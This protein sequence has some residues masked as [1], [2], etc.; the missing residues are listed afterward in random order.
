MSP[1]SSSNDL[2]YRAFRNTESFSKRAIP[3]SLT[4]KRP[5]FQNI[6]FGKN[7]SVRSFSEFL[8]SFFLHI[9]HVFSV[10]RREKMIRVYAW[11]IIAA[12]AYL[13]PFWNRSEVNHP[14]NTMGGMNADPRPKASIPSVAFGGNPN[15][16][17]SKRRIFWDRAVFTNLFPESSF[18]SRIQEGHRASYQVWCLEAVG[19]QRSYGFGV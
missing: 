17:R 4:R 7:C 3:Y 1:L 6:P 13:F 11:R 10:S 5:D 18:A 14:G 19:V 8:P 9:G 12:M 15:P 2:A 16:A